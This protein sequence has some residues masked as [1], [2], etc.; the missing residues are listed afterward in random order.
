MPR[1]MAHGFVVLSEEAIFS[2]KVDNIYSP[3]HEATLAWNDPQVD[4]DWQIDE[5]EL[6]LSDKDKLGVSLGELR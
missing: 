2:Y 4:I 5:K 1:N 6:L 3:Q